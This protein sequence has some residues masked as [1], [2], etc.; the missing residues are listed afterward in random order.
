MAIR[1]PLPWPVILKTPRLI[2]RPY[3][4]SDYAAWAEG[5]QARGPA[6]NEFDEGPRSAAALNRARFRRI[7][8]IN[9]ERAR[10]DVGYM[11][12]IF[13]KK[14]GRVVGWL[15]LY[16]FIRGGTQA[17]NF[18]YCLHNQHWGKGFAREAARAV[19]LGAFR[20]LK[21]HRL[22][23]SIAPDN[24]ASLRLIKALGFRKEGR[25]ARSD[26]RDGKWQD[27]LIYAAIPEDFRLPMPGPRVQRGRYRV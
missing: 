13:E 9:R 11:W 4:A 12:A 7:L 18:G 19:A 21:V 24:R 22:E 10:D 16:I 3:E 20:H 2:L 6:R 23:A 25:R 17:A 26:W 27:D 15:D 8:K 5:F 1:P 14:T